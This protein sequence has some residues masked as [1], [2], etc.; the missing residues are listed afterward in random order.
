MKPNEPAVEWY[1]DHANIAALARAM[2]DQGMA[3]SVVAYMVEKPWKYSCEFERMRAGLPLDDA[4]PYDPPASDPNTEYA[5][6]EAGFSDSKE[7]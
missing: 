6:A 4:E 3:A 2:A 1:E 5:R 7:P